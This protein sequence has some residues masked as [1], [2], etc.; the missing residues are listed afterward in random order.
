MQKPKGDALALLKQDHEAVSALFKQAEKDEKAQE[1][2]FSEI[3]SA[4]TI[5]ATIEEEIFYPAVRKAKSEQ[6]KDEVLEAL[7]EHKQ[8]KAL[9]TELS[10]LSGND[11]SFGPKL[12]VLKEDVEH[13]VE[14]EQDEMFPDAKK[15]LGE[16]RLVELGLQ[17]EE[18]KQNLR[19]EMGLEVEEADDLRGTAST[20]EDT[21]AKSHSSSKSKQ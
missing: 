12:K 13:H 6:V 4:L 19:A 7:A 15:Y 5:H 20:K 3:N 9:L 18:R 2:I 14:E 11:D 16:K 8:I 17:L 1:E 10:E 21:K